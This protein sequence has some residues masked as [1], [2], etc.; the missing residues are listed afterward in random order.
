MKIRHDATELLH[1]ALII[2]NCT[3]KAVVKYGF[4]VHLHFLISVLS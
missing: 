4:T 2:Y 3:C 1:D